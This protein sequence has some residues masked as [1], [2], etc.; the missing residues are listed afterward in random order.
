MKQS[1]LLI[2]GL[3]HKKETLIEAM[4]L[5]E[6]NLDLHESLAVRLDGV[7]CYITDVLK[8]HNLAELVTLE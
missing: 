3:K 6:E 2:L 1:L 7:N 4:Y 8:Y 5:I